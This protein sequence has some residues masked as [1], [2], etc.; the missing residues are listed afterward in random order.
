MFVGF[1]GLTWKTG[2]VGTPGITRVKGV[3]VMTVWGKRAWVGEEGT[4]GG[5]WEVEG[6]LG[7]LG[8]DRTKTLTGVEIESGS[9]A[10]GPMSVCW[11]NV[12][13]FL[14][15]LKTVFGFSNMVGGLGSGLFLVY[16]RFFLG[17]SFLN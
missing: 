4:C 13:W 15:N 16:L 2:A 10:C 5:L 9:S 3:E 8:V 17:A 12:C 6:E 14:T 7:E 1:W 11:S